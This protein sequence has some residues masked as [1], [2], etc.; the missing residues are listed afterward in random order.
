M[1]GR[2][3]SSFRPCAAGSFVLRSR[4]GALTA[5]AVAIVVA[6]SAVAQEAANGQVWKTPTHPLAVDTVSMARLRVARDTG[7]LLD[8][9]AAGTG[10]LVADGV[11]VGADPHLPV[12]PPKPDYRLAP[13]LRVA[14]AGTEGPGGLDLG[15]TVR[16]LV[17]LGQDI[18]LHGAIAQS[19]VGTFDRLGENAPGVLP[20]VR[21]DRAYEREGIRGPR[22]E[23]LYLERLFAL[24]GEIWAR[25][26]LG[27]LEPMYA[28][29]AAEVLWMPPDSA[30]ALG[31]E[32]NVRRARAYRQ[33]LRL[34]PLPGLAKTGGHASL[35]WQTPIAG[36]SAQLDLG[37][38]LA[39]D[40]GGTLTL[41]RRYA[42]GVRL[43]AYVTR[44]DAPGGGQ[45]A[46][47]FLTLPLAVLLPRIG[48]GQRDIRLHDKAED[49]GQRL[50]LPG[51]LYPRLSPASP[52]ALRQGAG[53]LAR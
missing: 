29:A 39:G 46:G 27:Y 11:S 12:P 44:T 21:S 33:D 25:T 31:A 53:V 28:G 17:P 47:V 51:R 23:R 35:Y 3:A 18:L 6:G 34:R 4:I 49:A 43:G 45:D 5:V 2:T 48:R 50:D 41:S 42:S 19:V 10:A 32:V 9:G 14:R 22:L 24:S 36:V 40:T 20:Q 1:R 13:Y 37:R 52:A 16:G 26:A 8:Q 7:H 30:I 38:Y 15:L